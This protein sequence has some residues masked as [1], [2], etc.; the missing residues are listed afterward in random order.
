MRE[1]D[2]QITTVLDSHDKPCRR[3]GTNIV[4]QR[5]PEL[6][7]G[8]VLP[9]QQAP[10]HELGENIPQTANVAIFATYKTNQQAI[11]DVCHY[12]ENNLSDIIQLPE[13]FFL[14]D[15]TITN[16]AEQR[17]EIARLSTQLIEQVSAE[18]RPYQYLCT[19]LILD[20]VHQAVIISAQGIFARQPQLHFCQRYQWTTLGNECQ[21]IELP[22]EQG[23]IKVAM[24]TADDNHIADLVDLAALNNIHLL[25]VPFDIQA[26][27]EVEHGLLAATVKHSICVVA[28][29]REKSFAAKDL[30]TD[31]AN[32]HK[33][34]QAKT[35][36][37]KSTG[38]IINVSANVNATNP[39]L[40]K[41]QHGKITKAVVHPVRADKKS[42]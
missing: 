32:N 39:P 4:N 40:L 25:L 38:F 17:A 36:S 11:E 35:K 8:T 6:Y 12:I 31:S 13:L 26:P 10:A 41:P 23:N 22:L 14:A 7:Q 42:S 1:A 33:A 16:N 5:R 20:G 27:N 3:D 34:N 28:A 18:L 30:P 15:K 21:I 29:T 9:V 37:Q 24:L 19:S 2:T